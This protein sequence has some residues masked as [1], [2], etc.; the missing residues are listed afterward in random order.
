MRRPTMS[1][2]IRPSTAWFVARATTG[3]S[4][5]AHRRTR[6]IKRVNPT[7]NN[8]DTMIIPR[9]PNGPPRNL[10]FVFP[11]RISTGYPG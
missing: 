11:I 4:G 1:R 2:W 7:D 3:G 5:T 6:L 8:T 10:T 9:Q